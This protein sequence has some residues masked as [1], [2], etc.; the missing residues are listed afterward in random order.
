MRET[1][2][3]EIHSRC[4]YVCVCMFAV[5]C[6]VCV[7]V[8]VRERIAICNRLH[9]IH[10]EQ[11]GPTGNRERQKAQKHFRNNGVPLHRTLLI[12][13]LCKLK[14]HKNAYMA[15]VCIHRAIEPSSHRIERTKNGYGTI[16]KLKHKRKSNEVSKCEYIQ[17]V[18][19]DLKSSVNTR[20]WL[21]VI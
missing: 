19:T 17:I 6:M 5:W 16:V 14:A 13:F 7:C 1:M 9:A 2:K 3:I 4:G 21:R 12:L 10:A 20:R 18:V 11:R 8:C 15:W